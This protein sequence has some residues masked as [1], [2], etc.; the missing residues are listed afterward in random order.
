MPITTLPTRAE[1]DPAFTW[2][3]SALYATEDDYLRDLEAAEAELEQ[4]APYQGRLGESAA[5]LGEFM[6]HYW[7]LLAKAER[8]RTYASLPVSVDQGDQEARQRA[9]RFQAFAGRFMA[10]T[11]FVQPELLVVG[12]QRLQAFTQAD[13]RLARLGR[14]FELVERDRPHTRSAEVEDVLSGLHDPFG[15]AQRAY[16]SLT[17]GEL[18]FAP[19]E[20]DGQSFE[21]ARSTY[22]RLRMSEDREVRR[23]AY[24]AYT[25]G[26]LAYANTITDLYLGQVKQSAYLANVRGYAS[27]VEEQL[28]PREVPRD[29][30]E[31]VVDV[32]KSKLGVWHRYWEARRKLLGVDRLEEWDVFAPLAVDA[33]KV[34]YQ[35]A[36]DWIVEGMAPLGEVYVEPMRRGLQEERWVDVYPNK[37][38]RDG[39][40]CA[41]A[42]GSQPYIMVSYQDELESLSTLAHELGHA[43]HS[44]LLDQEQPM[45]YATYSMVAAETAS[46]FNQALVR[47]HLLRKLQSPVERLALLEETFYNFHRYFFIMPT[48]VRFELEVH[49]AVERGEGLTAAKLNETMR[50]LFQEGYGDHIDADERVGTTW[51]QF[52]HLYVPFYTFQ[53]AAGIAAANALAADIDEGKE[54]AVESY[55]AFLRAGRSVSTVD[56]LLIAGVDLT[57]AAPIERAFEVLEGYVV[58]LEKLAEAA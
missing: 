10:T 4:I 42:Y 56:S 12:S 33:P 23:K 9:G 1:L 18:P 44:V 30:L 45:A 37:G 54:G 35:Q 14:Y 21:V 39:A 5:V 51:S 57:T 24:V 25:D 43:M 46:N 15:T 47:R 16:S 17:N 19:V 49:Q 55:L 40:F 28:H 27:T 48:L 53:Y 32:F 20:H 13:P 6:D 52:G 38:K 31:N 36:C 2:N 26:F 34:P 7:A 29:V 22:P 11:A 50:R 41:G 58:E 8:L 3:L